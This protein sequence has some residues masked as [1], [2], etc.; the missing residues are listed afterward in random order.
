MTDTAAGAPVF[1]FTGLSGAGKSSL[2]EAAQDRL[3]AGGFRVLI[4][5]GDQVRDEFHRDLGFT[6]GDIETNNRL[7]AELCADRRDKTDIMLVPI[8]SPFRSSRSAARNRLT[9]GFYEIYVKASVE[10]VVKRDVKG[11]YAKARDGEIENMIGYSRNGPPYEEPL[12]ADLVLDTSA[13][14]PEQS[15]RRLIDFIGAN[16]RHRDR[17][18]ISRP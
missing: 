12:Q 4:L 10:T 14:T 5:D 15:L 11:L 6:T 9:P 8:I 13:E 17:R 7:I 18:E 1:W 3:E 16:A 2:A